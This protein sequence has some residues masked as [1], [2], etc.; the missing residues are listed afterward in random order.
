MSDQLTIRH[1]EAK[2]SLELAALAYLAWEKGILPLFRERSGMRESEKR[3]LS[4]YVHD[5]IARII[6]AELDDEIVGWCSRSRDRAYI[7]YLFVLPGVQGRGIGTTLL[8]RMESLL[9]LEAHERV[10][11]ETPADHVSAVKFY[12]RQ[13]YRILAVKTDG[14]SPHEPLMSVRLEKK[15]N[16]FRGP[17][18]DID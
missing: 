16:P 9:E 18:R 1:A 2:E 15:L 17:I 3:R 7:P 10:S 4:T 6:V 8:R 12:E 14:R 5:N 11:L 13:G